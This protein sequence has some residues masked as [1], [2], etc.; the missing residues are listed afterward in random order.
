MSSNNLNL[1]LTDSFQ[2]GNGPTHN[3][4]GET[5]R[6]HGPEMWG[7]TLEQIKHVLD[8]ARSEKHPCGLDNWSTMR[9]VVKCFIK[10]ATNK[11][12][13]GYALAINQAKPLKAAVMVSVSLTIQYNHCFFFIFKHL[14]TLSIFYALSYTYLLHRA[15]CNVQS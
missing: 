1:Q 9:D 11:L 3:F 10:P 4:Q 6:G 12:G 15:V 14:L 5:Q 2:E 7:M 13:V 8:L